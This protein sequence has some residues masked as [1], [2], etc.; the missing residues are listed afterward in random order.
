MTFKTTSVDTNT[1]HSV[2]S[3]RLPFYTLHQFSSNQNT[4]PNENQRK[5][6]KMDLLGSIMNSMDKPPGTNDKEKERL[7][8]KWIIRI[9]LVCLHFA[10]A[11]SDYRCCRFTEQKEFEEKQRE[12]VQQDLQRFRKFCEERID[13]FVKNGER[14]SIQFQPLSKFYRS[15]MWVWGCVWIAA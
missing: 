4:L 9:F 11:N 7:R 5:R 14:K 10:I 6:P 3:F 1:A 12:R 2:E 13:R 15:V 8:S